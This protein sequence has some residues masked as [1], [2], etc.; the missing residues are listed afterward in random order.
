M[1]FLNV[2]P[3]EVAVV[4]W[5]T[6][7]LPPSV[8]TLKL[9]KSFNLEPVNTKSL[10]LISSFEALTLNANILLSVEPANNT[11]DVG[12]WSLSLKVPLAC[13][14]VNT[15]E[16][17]GAL[18]LGVTEVNSSDKSAVWNWTFN[19]PFAKASDKSAFTVKIIGWS[20]ITPLT[21]SKVIS[22]PGATS[23]V[24]VWTAFPLTYKVK[25]TLFFP[26]PV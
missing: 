9:F 3:V 5:S 16:G 17:A 21:F 13:A 8:I 11:W 6:T 19:V 12:F 26:L 20:V 4:A 10:N 2:T 7:T 24:L 1:I 14:I 15:A 23:N 22:L 25:K 18:T